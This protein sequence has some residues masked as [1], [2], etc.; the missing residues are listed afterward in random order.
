M[1]ANINSKLVNID[2]WLCANKLS[3]NIEKSNYV[4]FHARQRTVTDNFNLS[5]MNQPLKVSL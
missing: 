4:I 2:N 3:L 5:K 1:E